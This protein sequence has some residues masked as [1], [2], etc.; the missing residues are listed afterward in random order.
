MN[1]KLIKFAR[2]EGFCCMWSFLDAH[3]ETHTSELV[4]LAKAA[5]FTLTARAVRHQRRAYRRGKI[6]CLSLP[7]CLK[8]RL[9]A[10][11]KSD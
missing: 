1:E 10:A 3:R 8:A 6:I 11:R 2:I 5:G 4:K 7:S 9:S